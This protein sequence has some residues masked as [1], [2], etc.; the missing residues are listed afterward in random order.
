[1]HSHAARSP[2][3]RPAAAAMAVVVND[4]FLPDLLHV[5]AGSLSTKGARADGDLGDPVGA[6]A[7]RCELQGGGG[8]VTA[9][10][11]E[12]A[13]TAPVDG[14]DQQGRARSGQ[15]PTAS[16]RLRHTQ[17]PALHLSSISTN[18]NSKSLALMT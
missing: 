7:Q 14:S 10:G 13:D 4:D 9:L 5:E 8:R 2:G 11:A 12:N 15:Q 3:Q 6:G 17:I 18:R 1:M 16:D